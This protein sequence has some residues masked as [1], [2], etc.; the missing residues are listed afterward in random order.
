MLVKVFSLTFNSLMGGFDDEPLRDFMKDKEI[1]S[2]NDHLFIRNEI[3]YLT[4]IVKY[5]PF[6]QE[7]QAKPTVDG[8]SSDKR[9]ESW[10]EGLSET[11]MGLFNLFRDWRSQRCKKEGVPPYV[12]LT[13]KEIAEIVKQRPQSLAELLKIAGVGKAKAEKYGEDILSISKINPEQPKAE[14]IQE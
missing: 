13:N 4:L 8:K 12:L 5:F 11:D 6:R 7:V 3:P 10:K 2:I 1:I 14:A 9:D